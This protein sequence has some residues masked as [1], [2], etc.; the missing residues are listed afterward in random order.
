MVKTIWEAFQSPP[1]RP[2]CDTTGTS[3]FPMKPVSGFRP[4]QTDYDRVKDDDRPITIN[5]A[6]S[7][8]R[9]T[10]K[11]GDITT[12]K[13]SVDGASNQTT[14]TYKGVSY[15]LTAAQLCQATH[16][17]FLTNATG[18]LENRDDLLLVFQKPVTANTDADF[19]FVIFPLLRSTTGPSL[20]FLT[21][22]HAATQNPPGPFSLKE[23]AP[24]NARATFF[25]YSTCLNVG[26]GAQ[27]EGRYITT[28]VC[29]EG[30]IISKSQVIDLLRTSSSVAATEQ[31]PTFRDCAQTLNEIG[32]PSYRVPG[33]GD[34]PVVSASSFIQKI[35][36]TTRILDTAPIRTSAPPPSSTVG[37]AAEP[38]SAYKCITVDPEADI[39]NDQ[40]KYQY[41]VTTGE[42]LDAVLKEREALKKQIKDS[43]VKGTSNVSFVEQWLAIILAGVFGLIFIVVLIYFFNPSTS[44][45]G[46]A[47]PAEAIGWTQ[48]FLTSDVHR[49]V[50]LIAEVLLIVGLIVGIIYGIIYG[51][52]KG[53]EAAAS[54]IKG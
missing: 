8:N 1:T 4:T 31:N 33:E 7:A 28:F 23:F 46:S 37:T 53:T 16:S 49:L 50:G 24:V 12:G 13:L 18:D 48:A 38:I 15:A 19:V 9:P 47:A 41:D 51:I 22:L 42:P 27:L 2:Q 32:F 52:G 35:V 6:T 36:S 25:Y 44:D 21:G 20:K 29:A 34:A 10:F 17:G 40:F 5:W 26:T 39:E 43:A 54:A 11:V 45:T 3:G 14:A 30:T